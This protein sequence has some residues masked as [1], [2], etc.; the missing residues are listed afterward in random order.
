LKKGTYKRTKKVYGVGIN[1]ADYKI[2]HQIKCGDGTRKT[3]WVCPYYS[4]WCSMLERC[5]GR[6]S[7]DKRPTYAGVTI[8]DE[9]LTFSNFKAWME[10]QDWEGKYL[11]KDYMSVITGKKIYSPENCKFVTRDL[12][13]FL[14]ASGSKR[15]EYPLGVSY[16]KKIGKYQSLIGANGLRRYLGVFDDPF[17]AH[18]AWQMAK[19]EL[20]DEWIDLLDDENLICAMERIRGVLKEDWSAGRITEK[21]V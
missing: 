4:T 19:I 17:S 14:T 20:C 9:W 15:G 2:Y 11:D 13:N 16:K 18:K 21:L 8:C 12:N 7:K 5:Y 3:L 6:R 10:Q 1:D